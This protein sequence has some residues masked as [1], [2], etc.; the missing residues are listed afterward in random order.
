MRQEAA[1]DQAADL[2]IPEPAD[3]PRSGPRDLPAPVV[4]QLPGISY[5]PVT[6]AG[7]A[8]NPW[9]IVGGVAIILFLISRRD[10][11]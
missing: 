10:G 6:I 2:G 7:M 11:R 1:A 4:T 8:L 3:Y 5:T 9:V